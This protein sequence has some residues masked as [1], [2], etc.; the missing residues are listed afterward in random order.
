MVPRLGQTSSWA[1]NWAWEPRSALAKH[2]VTDGDMLGNADGTALG[3][4]EGRALGSTLG[5]ADGRALGR[6]EV[7]VLFEEP[8]FAWPFSLGLSVAVA[9]VTSAA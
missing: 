9:I 1:T 5:S 7:L 2:L 4:A 3:N 8:R 6:G